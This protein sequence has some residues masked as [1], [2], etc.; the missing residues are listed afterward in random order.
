MNYQQYLELKRR[1]E[2]KIKIFTFGMYIASMLAFV[3][4]ALLVLKVDFTWPYSNLIILDQLY[5]LGYQR[6]AEGNVIF[7][8]FFYGA[9]ALIAIALI[10][11]SFLCSNSKRSFYY[12]I[13]FIY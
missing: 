11:S 10:A 12:L 7:A 5:S 8:L 13:I 6:S 2:I 3:Q 4:T 1:C 9:F